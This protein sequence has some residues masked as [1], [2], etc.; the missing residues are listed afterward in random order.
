MSMSVAIGGLRHNS[1]EIGLPF[2]DLYE[3]GC[4]PLNFWYN[5]ETTSDPTSLNVFV[6]D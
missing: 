6:S 1:S 3:K 5:L 2:C 4:W